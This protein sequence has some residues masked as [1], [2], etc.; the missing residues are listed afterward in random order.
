MPANETTSN[1]NALDWNWRLAPSAPEWQLDWNAIS[2]LEWFKAM[3][4]CKQ[5]PI[6]H[7]EGDVATHV[8]LVCEALLAIERWRQLDG[9]ER[10]TALL[11]AL[12][13]DIAKPECTV[14]D[15]DGRI[16]SKDHGRRG[17][18]LARKILWRGDGFIDSPPP[19]AMREEISSMI[20]YS[21]LPLWLWDK[22]DPT[23]SIIRASQNLRLDL[24]A[25]LAEADA[26][27]RSCQDLPDLLSRIK[28]FCEYA[29]EHKCFTE[30]FKFPSD[31]S[32]F[33]YFQKRVDSSSP[34]YIDRTVY[35]D[36]RLEV[37]LM[38]GLPAAGKDSWIAKNANS[39]PVVS[40]DSIR[41]RHKIAADQDQ[42]KVV[43]AAREE[44]RQLMRDQKSFIWNGTNITRFMRDPLLRFFR[45]YG[46]SIRIVYVE[47][48]NY[49]ELLRRNSA[50]E[51]PVPQ[52]VIEKL[53]DKLE[54][55][56]LSEAHKLLWVS[57]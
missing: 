6:H 48:A 37:T 56:D 17:A 49:K 39:M 24:L 54:V 40:L 42:S 16:S 14:K 21:S 7:A 30:A 28:L 29:A 34:N 33:V 35:D 36:T 53:A 23:R 38:A 4:D 11:G 51:N 57:T 50:R 26:R 9:K 25:I 47:P 18:Q 19:L 44:A 20:R 52:K 3:I 32:R 15:E 45:D 12:L 5:D 46:A 27:G 10:I 13:H 31:H 43:Q 1:N 55:P 2:S 22:E 8:R 41:E